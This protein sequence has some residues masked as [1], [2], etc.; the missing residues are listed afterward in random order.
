MTKKSSKE[1]IEYEDGT[2]IELG[3]DDCPEWT[4]EDFKRA[5]RG[6][7]ALVEIFG[8]QGADDLINKRVTIRPDRPGRPV[9]ENPKQKVTI[10]LD[11]DILAMLRA[12]GAGWQTRLND[13]IRKWVTS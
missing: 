9:S 1:Y 13:Q 8:A 6:R 10:R 11:Q 7:E 3:P 4:E 2:R 5:K 12:S